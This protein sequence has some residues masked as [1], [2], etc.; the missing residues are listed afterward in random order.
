MKTLILLGTPKIGG[1]EIQGIALAQLLKSNG[2][3]VQIACLISSDEYFE[4]LHELAKGNNIEI[5]P[6]HFRGKNVIEMIININRIRKIINLNYE[7]CFGMTNTPNVITS[8]LKK[9]IVKIWMQRDI[10]TSRLFGFLDFI[11]A[12]RANFITSNSKS[13]AKFLRIRTLGLRKIKVVGNLPDSRLVAFADQ[14]KISKGAIKYVTVSNFK[15][16][17]NIELIIEA[18]KLFFDNQ[19]I[20][21]NLVKLQIIGFDYEYN[22]S[23]KYLNYLQSNYKI[24]II[25]SCANPMIYLNSSNIYLTS[26]NSESRSNSIDH[27]MY[28]GLTIVGFGHNS[29]LDQIDKSN[30][31]YMCGQ[32][33]VHQILEKIIE[34][35]NDRNKLDNIGQKN[36]NKILNYF[37]N[38]V[39]E[40][41]HFL[42]KLVQ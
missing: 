5:I 25:N 2:F 22:Y 14:I 6:L 7:I 13:G 34:A 15:F 11:C 32:N 24:E 41:T 36:R 8:L 26:T 28:Y 35:Y 19:T 29:I 16:S 37:N 12:L 21:K 18:W 38:S 27:A 3:Q 20:D 10:Q 39:E 30:Y 9:D 17:K 31:R 33:G 23:P 4:D 40:W 42:S 1:A